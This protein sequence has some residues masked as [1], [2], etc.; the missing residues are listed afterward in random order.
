MEEVNLKKRGWIIEEL[1]EGALKVW[2]R[3]ERKWRQRGFFSENGGR[4]FQKGTQKKKLKANSLKEIECEKKK[5]FRVK[6]GFWIS[7]E[8]RNWRSRV[9][10]GYWSLL[11]DLGEIFWLELI[12]EKIILMWRR[13]FLFNFFF[14]IWFGVKVM[15]F[16]V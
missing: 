15:K 8:T 9:E 7:K 2:I 6:F 13:F 4:F 16:W 11:R 3:E 12:I 10:R 1:V 5:S 14:S